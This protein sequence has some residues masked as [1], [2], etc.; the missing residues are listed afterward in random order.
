MLMFLQ[1]DQNRLKKKEFWNNDGILKVLTGLK[2][3]KQS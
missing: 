1:N 2:L 3:L